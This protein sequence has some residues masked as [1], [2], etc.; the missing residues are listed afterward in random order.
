M[1]PDTD[2]DVFGL[3]LTTVQGRSY[4]STFVPRCWL[5]D[6]SDRRCS[7]RQREKETKDLTVHTGWHSKRVTFISNERPFKGHATSYGHTWCARPS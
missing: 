6:K 7:D 5:K 4:L 3:S 2:R 1:K